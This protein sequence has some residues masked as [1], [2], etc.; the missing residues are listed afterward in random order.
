MELSE[1]Q[2]MR[3]GTLVFLLLI[4]VIGGLVI[5]NRPV[6][7]LWV[8]NPRGGIRLVFGV[9]SDGHLASLDSNSRLTIRNIK[10]GAI[11]RS[12]DTPQVNEMMG[13]VTQDGKWILLLTLKPELVVISLEDGS[14]RY[15]PI[16][17]QKQAYP[18]LREDGR[19]AILPGANASPPGLDLLI[20][21]SQGHVRWSS[22]SQ[23]SFCGTYQDLVITADSPAFKT[24]RLITIS[25]Q[26][27][28]GAIA[29]PEMQGRKLASIGALADDRIALAYQSLVDSAFPDTKCRSARISDQQLVDIREEP[30]IYS[31][32]EGGQQVIATLDGHFLIRDLNQTSSGRSLMKFYEFASRIGLVKEW[33]SQQYSWQATVS[34]HPVGPSISLKS[35]ALPTKDGQY[36]VEAGP[37]LAVFPIS[38]RSRWPETLA[39]AA[40][41]WL[42]VAAWRTVRK[43][44]AHSPSLAGSQPVQ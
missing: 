8:D 28:M 34:G 24:Y 3:W 17:I 13:A 30:L 36:L 41:P 7:P 14:L 11:L 9:S 37:R 22:K 19:Y 32:N 27:D 42:L 39:V 31:R 43:R 21:L 2:R 23:L 4:S 1:K 35:F 12:F 40:L 18:I 44:R 33:S 26:R 10:T 16:P 29:V 6:K 5:W 20:D 25:D 38:R 15:P